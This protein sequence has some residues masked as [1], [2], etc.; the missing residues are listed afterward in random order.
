MKKEMQ[1][2]ALKNGTV[3]DHIPN[4][5][6]LRVVQ[7][8]GLESVKGSSI[9]VGYNLESSVMGSKSIIK[10]SDHYFSDAELGR[11]A[12]VAPNV[13]LC[14]IRDY[15]V[16]EKKKVVMPGSLRGIVRCPNPKC[17][18]N[19]EPMHTIFTLS[20]KDAHTLVCH[21]CEKEVGLEEV[22]FV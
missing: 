20:A 10:V 12:V 11:L 7:L 6:L 19:N 5:K 16:V 22:K 21:Y 1:V 8:L 18:T 3:I 2:A 14:I 9:M 13:T 4:E 15:E 17:I